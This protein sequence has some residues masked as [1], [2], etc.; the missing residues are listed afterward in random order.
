MLRSLALLLF[1]ITDPTLRKWVLFM[2]VG[3]IVGMC[4]IG[5]RMSVDWYA[6]ENG[7]YRLC[8]TCSCFCMFSMSVI[9]LDC[10]MYD[11]I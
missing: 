5:S 6:Y 11:W 1:L 9:D 4:C 2:S 3:S 7:W 10:C 8:W